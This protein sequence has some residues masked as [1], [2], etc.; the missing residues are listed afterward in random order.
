MLKLQNSICTCP[1]GS[2]VAGHISKF[3]IGVLSKPREAYQ[4]WFLFFLWKIAI[5]DSLSIFF[6]SLLFYSITIEETTKSIRIKEK[7]TTTTTEVTDR[8]A[9]RYGTYSLDPIELEIILSRT[10]AL[11]CSSSTE[12]CVFGDTAVKKL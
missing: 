5:F 9:S 3:P 1:C 7:T 8:R 6:L 2:E 10:K 11:R 12:A 4:L